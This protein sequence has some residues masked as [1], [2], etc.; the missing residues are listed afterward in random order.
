M[1]PN[2]INKYSRVILKND[3]IDI[4]IY[5][6]IAILIFILIFSLLDK[7]HKKISKEDKR[8]NL[9][10]FCNYVNSNIA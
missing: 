2:L 4:Y 8:K 3:I 7:F 9:I 10:E 6:A 1:K 5:F